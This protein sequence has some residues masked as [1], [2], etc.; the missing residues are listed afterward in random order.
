MVY[1][2]IQAMAAGGLVSYGADIADLI[3]IRSDCDSL[4]IPKSAAK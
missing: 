3:P 2:F 1:P 4:G